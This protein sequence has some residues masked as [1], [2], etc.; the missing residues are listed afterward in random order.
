MGGQANHPGASG[1]RPA[2]ATGVSFAWN[3][4]R[5]GP[6]G[7]SPPR[8]PPA[9]DVDPRVQDGGQIGQAVAEPGPDGLKDLRATGSP[10]TVP[11]SPWTR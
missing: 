11:W 1:A 6:T 5:A 2:A 4:S 9:D 8:T 3:V 7:S 10:A